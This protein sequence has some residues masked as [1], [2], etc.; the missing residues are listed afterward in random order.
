MDFF[1]MYPKNYI[2]DLLV[3]PLF[4]SSLFFGPW[5]V[6]KFPFFATKFSCVHFMHKDG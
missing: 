6:P 5:F 1:V 2:F 3:V 4:F